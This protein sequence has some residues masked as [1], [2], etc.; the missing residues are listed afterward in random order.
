MKFLEVPPERE[1]NTQNYMNDQHSL[2]DGVMFLLFDLNRETILTRISRWQV[3]KFPRGW[4]KSPNWTT[5]TARGLLIRLDRIRSMPIGC[6]GMD[7]AP[8]QCGHRHDNIEIQPPQ[9]TFSVFRKMEEKERKRENE[10]SAFK[11][12]SSNSFFDIL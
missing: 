2:S 10:E 6:P 12:E 9:Y 4:G 5:N 11:V 8:N 7:P 3:H 1:K